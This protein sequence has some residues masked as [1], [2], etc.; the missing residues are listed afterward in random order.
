MRQK[1]RKISNYRWRNSSYPGS[2][3]ILCDV[4]CRVWRLVWTHLKFCLF[5][6]IAG[7]FRVIRDIQMARKNNWLGEPQT[8][9]K[10][11]IA[12]SPRHAASRVTLTQLESVNEADRTRNSFNRKWIG[13]VEQISI[14][15]E[16][17]E[18][19]IRKNDSAQI[20]PKP[21]IFF[22]GFWIGESIISGDLKLAPVSV[23][24]LVS[25]LVWVL[26]SD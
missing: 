19:S 12:S 18:I 3:G 5:I 15:F 24:V 1:I 9:G 20:S 13:C 8:F 22:S 14:N 25:V 17:R 10:P 21:E 6:E 7:E 16:K 23:S 11:S 2:L 4:F 26:V